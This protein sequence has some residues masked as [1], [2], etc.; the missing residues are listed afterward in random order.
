MAT[1]NVPEYLQTHARQDP[2][3]AW[4]WIGCF[5]LSFT[6]FLFNRLL[7]HVPEGELLYVGPLLLGMW[8]P[9]RSRVV[10]L[11]GF[12]TALIVADVIW[13]S[14]AGFSWSFALGR[15]A[16]LIIIW[17]LAYVLLRG[18]RSEQAR[19]EGEEFTKALFDNIPIPTLCLRRSGMG[20]V[21]ERM[22][23]AA[24]ELLEV[25]PAEL[26]GAPATDLPIVKPEIQRALDRAFS[27]RSVERREID[28]AL[29]DASGVRRLAVTVASVPR[30]RVMLLC[31]D[32]SERASEEERRRRRHREL[33][34]IL[35]N[36]PQ[37]I[38]RLNRDH[39]C[40]YANAAM[41][42]M[43]GVPVQGFFRKRMNELS[44]ATPNLE[45]WSLA[46]AELVRT[47]E[48][49]TLTGDFIDGAGR[50]R[51][52]QAELIP[53]TANGVV[54]TVLVVFEDRLEA[55]ATEPA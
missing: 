41:A 19:R 10:K 30:D 50:V 51:P 23:S 2:P 31:E 8:P 44:F 38:L 54:E 34:A 37:G 20:F 53:E 47:A 4:F 46:L 42:S 18:E 5:G 45:K 21:L 55:G 24:G 22:N 35:S 40:V 14:M 39:R 11:A 49:R 43:T 33:S 52:F 6:F 26:V 16:S 29:S 36:I 3:A 13:S 12:G 17:G 1:P 7:L 25:S 15:M 9:V 32:V 48:P 27:H 28:F